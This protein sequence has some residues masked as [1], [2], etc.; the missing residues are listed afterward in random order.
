MDE[1]LADLKNHF[2]LKRIIF[3]IIPYLIF[4]F[5]IILT[6]KLGYHLN[7]M[8]IFIVLEAFI[9]A[10]LIWE[11]MNKHKKNQNNNS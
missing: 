4:S 7:Q 9:I 6:H 8:L 3:L 2:T 5:V 11:W 10:N 1:I